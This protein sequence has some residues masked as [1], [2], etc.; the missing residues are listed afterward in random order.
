[1]DLLLSEYFERR[2]NKNARHRGRGHLEEEEMSD[3]SPLVYEMG[4]F[5]MNEKKK[6]EQV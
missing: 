2:E 1:M 5:F 4:T 3:S 6:Y